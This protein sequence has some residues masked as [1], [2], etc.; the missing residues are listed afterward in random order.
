[1][2][3][4]FDNESSNSLL[5][6]PIW[7]SENDWLINQLRWFL[8]ATNKERKVPKRPINEK[9][10][11]E[12]YIHDDD[13]EYRWHLVKTLCGPGLVFPLA[14]KRVKEYQVVYDPTL[15]RSY[16]ANFHLIRIFY[17]QNHQEAV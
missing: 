2:G 17:R 10:F 11:P 16:L 4:N 13:C 14:T 7:L 5:E 15:H 6:R 9:T 12:L 8:N 1:M 3:E